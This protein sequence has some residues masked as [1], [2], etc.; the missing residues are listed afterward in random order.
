M[1]IFNSYVSHYQRVYSLTVTPLPSQTWCSSPRF[2]SRHPSAQTWPRT[3]WAGWESKAL[4]GLVDLVDLTMLWCMAQ[5]PSFWLRLHSVCVTLGFAQHFFTV[6]VIGWQN[7]ITFNHIRM[8]YFKWFWHVS[9]YC[10]LA[11][12]Q[13]RCCVAATF[14]WLWQ[15][16][17][18]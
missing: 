15:Q 9:T 7:K 10:I 8:D 3:S 16:T 11:V 1:V 13:S 17:T 18:A 12:V 5:P 2:C 6:S 14:H 4:K